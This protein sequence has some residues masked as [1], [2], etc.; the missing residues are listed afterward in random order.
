MQIAFPGRILTD[1]QQGVVDLVNQMLVEESGD[2]GMRRLAVYLLELSDVASQQEIAAAV[3]YSSD[4]TIRH[5]RDHITRQGLS[6]LVGDKPGRPGVT[7][8]P[9]VERAVI[10]EILSVVIE[11][12]RLPEDGQLAG[13]INRRLAQT[14]YEGETVT[15]TMIRTVRLRWQ[16]KR[17]STRQFLGSSPEQETE[18]SSAET[19]SLGYTRWGGAFVIL[20]L[21][22]R[23]A[24]LKYARLLSIVPNYAVTAE[25]LLLTAIFSTICGINRAF[26]LDDVR[27][28]G[29][30]LLT[31]R[32]RPLSHGTFQHLIH[33][34]SLRN[35]VRF[36]R[37]TSQQQVDKVE[38]GDFRV[39]MDGHTVA[40]F[41]K[42]VDLPKGRIGSTARIE[43]ADNLITAFE[44]DLRTFLA[45]RIR[46]G[47]KQLHKVVLSMAR[48]ILKLRQGKMGWLRLFLD[49]GAFYGFLFRALKRMPGVH[50]YTPAVRYPNFV[51]EWEQLQDKDFQPQPFVF[52]RDEDLPP[53]EQMSFRLADRT[54]EIN[55]WKDKKQLDT[56]TLRAVILFNPVGETSS[57]RWFVLLTDDEE[58]PACELANEYG[59]HWEH[60][61]AH[62]TGKH[63]LS[64]DILPPS[65][66]LETH[67][68]DDGKLLR[69]VKL[70]MKNTFMIAWLRCL[71]FNLMTAFGNTLGG[72]Y[73]KIYSGTLLRKFIHRPAKLLLVGDELHLVLDPFTEQEDLYPL[74]EKLNEERIPVPWL[75]GMVLQ[76]FIDENQPLHPL[77]TP[78][79]RKR[80]FEK[81]K[82]KCPS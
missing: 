19:I 58:T 79:K 11:E 24:W 20:G 55:V 8:L 48:E 25:Q 47:A 44:L 49:R 51:E 36:Y 42:I 31:G 43:K 56:V 22:I 64:Y 81:G 6:G 35:V 38:E 5:I 37:A 3:G 13:R 34:L 72:K 59:D 76:F 26:H 41:T 10:G 45:L 62:R 68:E 18:A 65:Y 53:K 74:L 80:F 1:K 71:T 23:D 21:L 33:T 60:E 57:E 17:P 66:T 67:H 7:T 77:T 28:T 12:H 29:F 69:K 30:A 63:D 4:R 40:R 2:Q 54:M 39:S 50:F 27:D 32:S 14:G 82:P 70:N 9:K 52:D 16:I 78:E 15:E 75:N 61:S 46:R 73:A